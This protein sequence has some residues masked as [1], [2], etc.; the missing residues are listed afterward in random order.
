MVELRLPE[1][2]L[3]AGAAAPCVVLVHGGYWRQKYD[4]TYLAPFAVELAGRGLPVALV[5]YRRVDGGSGGWPGTAEDVAAAVAAV[6]AHP[7]TAGRP[8]V[9]VGHSAGGQLAL[10]AAVRCLRPRTGSSPSRRSRT[11]AGRTNWG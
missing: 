6:R 7:A 1:E 4:R 2:P 9:V 8:L 10:W 3:A 5:E 11:C